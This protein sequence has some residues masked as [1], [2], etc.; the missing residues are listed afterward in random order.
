MPFDGYRWL[1]EPTVRRNAFISTSSGKNQDSAANYQA[2]AARLT[3]G[4]DRG[5]L[6][7]WGRP[8]LN[9][10]QVDIACIISLACRQRVENQGRQI[11]L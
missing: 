7:V 6:A 8:R 4:S 11:S 9:A 3:Y 2:L 5:H 10:R 1:I